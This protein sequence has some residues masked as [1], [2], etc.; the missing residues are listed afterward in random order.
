M[1]TLSAVTSPNS[2]KRDDDELQLANELEGD[3]LQFADEDDETLFAS[4]E[5][6][7]LSSTSASLS[8]TTTENNQP[9]FI[10]PIPARTWKVVIIDDDSEVHEVT[11]FALQDFTFGN[12]PLTFLSAYSGQEA[13]ELLKNHPDAAVIFLDVVMEENDSGLKIV[14]YIR[15][16]L[17]NYLVRIILRTGQPGEAPEE[18]IIVDYDINDYKLK[19]DLTQRKLFVTMIAA[20]RA[21]YDLMT[22]EINK[23]ALKQTLDAM[24]VGVCVLEAKSNKLTFVN[25]P[26]RQLLGKGVEPQATAANFNINYQ[27]RQAGSS[28]WYP[29]EQLPLIRALQGQRSCVNDI[30]IR[31]ADQI[32]PIESCGTP[33]FDEKQQ[34]IYALS[35]FQD[36]TERQRAQANKIRLAQEEAAKQAAWRHSEEIAVKNANLIQLNQEKNEFLG[37]VAHDLKNPLSGLKGYAEDIL[38]SFEELS[39]EELIELVSKIKQGAIQMFNLVVNLLDVNAIESGKLNFKFEAV[40]IAPIMQKVINDYQEQAQAK[41]IKLHLESQTPILMALVDKSTCEGI[42]D[43]LVSNAIK[44]SPLDKNIYIRLCQRD[45][46]I[47]SEV[48][49]EGPGLSDSDLLK[50]FGKFTRLSSKP[51][52]G[53]HSTGLGLF[54]V[55]KLVEAMKGKVW[56]E[57][58]LGQGATF[59]VEF[60]IP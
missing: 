14:K 1:N 3:E 13:Q 19:T 22:L 26:A 36:I 15:E 11:Q 35:V 43:N 16:T 31:Q 58:Q 52:G 39:K 48:Q 7:S 29:L 46:Y 27:L 20:L 54:I 34:V 10:N 32:I 51:T 9:P 17:Q 8:I 44:Y 33:I 28:E 56:C 18:K 5:P 30:E 4:E 6:T 53:E 25:Q 60:P 12:K 45:S 38:D 23:L 24:P 21:Y 42:L 57:S 2:D 59:I 47:H 41:N 40:D 37:V 55:K 50:L 49:D